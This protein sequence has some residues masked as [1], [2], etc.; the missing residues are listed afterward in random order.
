M[1]IVQLLKICVLAAFVGTILTGVLFIIRSS[2][3]QQIKAH[4]KDLSAKQ[5]NQEKFSDNQHIVDKPQNIPIEQPNESVKE[6]DD[7]EEIQSEKYIAKPPKVEHE[8]TSTTIAP[9]LTRASVTTTTSTSP[10]TTT[11]QEQVTVEQKVLKEL[12]ET[13]RPPSVHIFYYPWYGSPEFDNGKYYH[14]IMR[15]PPTTWR[16]CS[17]FY[18]RLGPYSS[19]DPEVVEQHMKWLSSAGIDVVIVSWYPKNKADDEGLPWDSLMPLLLNT[20]E[21]V[22]DDIKYIINTYGNHSAFYRTAKKSTKKE[23]K[24]LPLMGKIATLEGS[25]TIRG[26]EWD[27]ILI[28]LYLNSEHKDKIKKANFDGIYTY[29]ASDG[30]TEGSTMTNWPALSNFCATSNLLFIPSVGPGYVDTRVRPALQD[31]HI[32]KADIISITSFNEWHEGTQIEPAKPFQDTNGTDFVYTQYERG[33]E[34]YLEITL[35]MIKTYFTPHHENIPM[36]IAR[37]V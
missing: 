8:D 4:V 16:C 6:A 13:S 15:P 27:S 35:E 21:S 33:P 9:V 1:N 30:F 24:E 20:A 14:W 36:Q 34:Q 17:N 18:P 3:E 19:S 37:I 32:A 31:G 28:G 5:R 23:V 11:T 29:F 26:T 22:A 2:D 12:K 25:S 7:P 10:A